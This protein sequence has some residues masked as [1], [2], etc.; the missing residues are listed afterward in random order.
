LPGDFFFLTASTGGAVT[1]STN[2]VPPLIPGTSYYLC[3]LNNNPTN[4]TFAIRVDFDVLLYP[5]GVVV[6]DLTNAVPYSAINPGGGTNTDYYHFIVST[7][8]VRAQFEI[9]NATGDMTLVARK[10]L[11]LPSLSLYDA[12]SS[13]NG[14]NDELIVLFAGGSPVPLTP[15][16]WFLSAINV[17]G[18]PVAYTIKAS[19]FS[20]LGT[21][22]I[23][24][25]FLSS[26]AF[27]LSWNSL[28]DV[29]YVVQGRPNLTT[30]G[31]TNVSP[32]ITATSTQTTWCVTL[33]SPYSFFRVVEGLAPAPSPGT[34]PFSSVQVATNGVVLKW[35]APISYRFQV[36]WSPALVPASWTTFTNI[37]T[38]ATGVFTFTDNGSQTGGL[39][40]QRYYR[41]LLLP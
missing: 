10:G 8:A 15:G 2:T 30:P 1:I 35:V 16:D 19:E 9:Y 27:C 29:H 41:L 37:V 20:V 17:S 18:N 25:S 33:P 28:I 31:W 4:V 6:I 13:N 36:Q 22:I 39:G 24:T 11:P 26:N 3:V 34:I 40:T 14:L 21:N 7:N 23:V 12:I 38:S 5:P 32:T